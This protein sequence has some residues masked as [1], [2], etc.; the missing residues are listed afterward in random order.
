MPLRDDS[1]PPKIT[2]HKA[3]SR[4]TA[5]N[6][7]AV[8]GAV[9]VLLGLWFLVVST[10]S[11]GTATAR[12]DIERRLTDLTGQ[13]VF[14]DGAVT[15][16]LLPT[17]L[18]VL[19]DVRIGGVGAGPF[20]AVDQLR[21]QLDLVDALLGRTDIARL[22]LVRPELSFV[23]TPG[24]GLPMPD[25]AEARGGPGIASDAG[26]YGEAIA[27]ARSFFTR[28]EGVRLIEL[29]EGV[30]RPQDGSFGFSNADLDLTWSER[31][32]PAHVAGS[33]VWNGQPADLDMQIESPVAFL[34]GQS[35]ELSLALTSPPMQVSFEGEGSGGPALSLNGAFALSSP[36]LPRSAQWV[37]GSAVAF[38][39]FGAAS[40]DGELRLD[41][42]QVV[43]AGVRVTVGDQSGQGALEAAFPRGER[44]AISGTL[45]FPELNLD[46]FTRGVAPLPRHALDFQRPMT[47]AFMEDFDLDLRLSAADAG[48][49]GLP[50]RQFAAT[51]I[52]ADGV[53][54]LDV[55]D[56]EL[57]GGR[58]QGRF[59][60]DL[61]SRRPRAYGRIDLAGVDATGL[62]DLVG[63]HSFGVSGRA[64][65][66]AQFSAPATNWGEVLRENELSVS[67]AISEGS[68]AGLSP[69]LFLEPGERQLTVAPSAPPVAFTAV[70]ADLT[71][72][73][74][75]ASLN[76]LQIRGPEGMI[77]AAGF[78]S[79]LDDHLHVEGLFSPAET[80]SAGDGLFTSS[81][82]IT[83][84]MQ[85]KWPAPTVSVGQGGGPI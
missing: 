72:R 40:L 60:I 33:F 38:P 61:E 84:K 21:A 82:P 34:D 57:L 22:T 81:Q 18:L 31:D 29:R 13:D 75:Y 50:L 24:D 49:A 39:D 80:A 6:V 30:F 52:F 23:E 14:V 3:L 4:F 63:I 5:R 66:N 62:A 41:R 44:P 54:T 15:Y 10:L 67:L 7:L 77:E 74:P 47:V 46:R 58:A 35:S 59:S 37:G 70:E 83:F 76:D 11:L 2:G 71:T 64:N 42:D 48:V 12:A 53:A 85:G 8:G 1:Q 32:A 51:V 16:E 43:L 65:L 68:F 20:L 45:A 79:L 27:Y 55:G 78:L 25:A 9:V 26:A 73:G 36:S 69:E 19:S 28:F 56:A 17:P